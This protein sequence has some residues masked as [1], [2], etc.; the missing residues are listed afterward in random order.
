[1]IEE[2][3]REEVIV[4]EAAS[5]EHKVIS[6]DNTLVAIGVSQ[7][8]ETFNA[9]DGVF[10]PDTKGT[11]EPIFSLL[12]GVQGMKL[13]AFVGDDHPQAGIILDNAEKAQINPNTHRVGNNVTQ[14]GLFE[15]KVILADAGL[16][17]GET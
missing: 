12:L 2:L 11:N 9:S 15:P 6:Q 1:M 10:S 16:G 4:P 7:A 8:A 17:L 3:G 5:N 13:T 14:A